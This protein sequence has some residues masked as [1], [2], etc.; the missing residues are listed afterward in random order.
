MRS[1]AGRIGVLDRSDFEARAAA[2]FEDLIHFV[3]KELVFVVGQFAVNVELFKFGGDGSGAG[4]TIFFDVGSFP[5]STS[6]GVDQAGEGPGVAAKFLV[7]IA[8]FD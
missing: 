2:D 3:E 6:K 7:E 8:G 4:V 5:A 1:C